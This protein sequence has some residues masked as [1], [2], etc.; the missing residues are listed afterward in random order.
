[1][2]QGRQHFRF[3]LEPPYALRVS[4]KRLGKDFQRHLAPQTQIAGAVH[5]SHSARA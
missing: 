4:G 2:I 5:L 1:M 3:A